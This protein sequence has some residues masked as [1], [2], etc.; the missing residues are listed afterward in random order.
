MKPSKDSVEIKIFHRKA[1][2]KPQVTYIVMKTGREYHVFAEIEA[3]RA[4]LDCG[5]RGTREKG[6]VDLWDSIWN[7]AQS[8]P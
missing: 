6:T 2:T 8:T 1:K 4:A 3:K 7:R 5:A